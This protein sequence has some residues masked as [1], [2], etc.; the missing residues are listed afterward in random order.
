MIGGKVAPFTRAGANLVTGYDYTG[1]LWNAQK[2]WW[3]NSKRIGLSVA[4][5][6][7]PIPFGVGGVTGA[8][9][10]GAPLQ[11]PTDALLYLVVGSGLGRATASSGKKGMKKSLPGLKHLKSLGEVVGGSGNGR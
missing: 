10:K 5:S 4:G 7:A 6:A 8:V 3:E 9:V 2:S 11:T 1:K